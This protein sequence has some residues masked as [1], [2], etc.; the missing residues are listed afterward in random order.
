M[1]IHVLGQVWLGVKLSKNR[2]NTVIQAP[3]YFFF[4]LNSAEHEI[5]PADKSRITNKCFLFTC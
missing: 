3:G 1:V 5:C 2:V 4:M